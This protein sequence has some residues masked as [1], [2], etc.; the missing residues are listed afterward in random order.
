MKKFA[1]G[2]ARLVFGLCVVMTAPAWALG[3]SAEQKTDAPKVDAKEAT[4]AAEKIDDKKCEGITLT[5]EKFLDMFHSIAMHGDL[6]DVPFIEKTLKTKL[7]GT[8]TDDEDEKHYHNKSGRFTGKAVLGAPM[9]IQL[10]F[11]SKH[12]AEI[13]NRTSGIMHIDRGIYKC[14]GITI[15]EFEKKFGGV[16]SFGFATGGGSTMTKDKALGEIG[17][18]GS[19]INVVGAYNSNDPQ[20]IVHGVTIRQN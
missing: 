7:K 6:T 11:N 3:D 4:P 16:F 9:D 18:D 20:R 13:K 17:K 12:V 8:S 10:F 19:R 14:L 1:N 5:G 15:D 2:F